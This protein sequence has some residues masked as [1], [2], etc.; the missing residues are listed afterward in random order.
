MVAEI[1]ESNK[2][3][4]NSDILDFH[5]KKLTSTL[6]KQKEYNNILDEVSAKVSQGG[7]SEQLPK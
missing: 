7:T 3:K 1:L 5:E 4:Q 2:L 6:I